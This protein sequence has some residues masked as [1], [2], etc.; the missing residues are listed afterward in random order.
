MQPEIQQHIRFGAAA[1]ANQI[2]DLGNRKEKEP[3][4]LG[5]RGGIGKRGV[6]L[7]PT[8]DFVTN[9]FAAGIL[10]T[11]SKELPRTLVGAGGENSVEFDGAVLPK[12]FP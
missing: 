2:R 3:R 5:A 4:V 8:T 1:G 12:F 10:F 7:M 6:G 11:V 9:E